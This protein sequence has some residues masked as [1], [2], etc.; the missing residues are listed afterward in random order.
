MSVI[1]LI[2]GLLLGASLMWAIARARMSAEVASLEA[3][4]N[5]QRSIAEEKV[6]VLVEA[7]E[8]LSTQLRAMCA[9]ALRGN[10]E[11]FI[12]LAK[13]QFA[14]LQLEARHDLDSRQKAVENLVG[15]IKESLE[16]VGPEVKTL[17]KAR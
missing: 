8:E 5:H 4:L 9:E 7:R 3:E 10:N 14:Q 2:V 15:P 13:S 6:A 16:R 17:E 12:Q 11:Q 1:F